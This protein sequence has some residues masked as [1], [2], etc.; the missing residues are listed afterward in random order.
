MLLAA[1]LLLALAA[2]TPEKDARRRQ[3]L[4]PPPPPVAT[5]P[6]PAAGADGSGAT[7]AP[8]EDD[9]AGPRPLLRQP[10]PPFAYDRPLLEVDG[11]RIMASELNE[12]VLYYRSFRPGS[13]DLLLMDAVAALLPLKAVQSRYQS[14]LFAMRDRV[15]Q[16]AEALRDGA[17]FAEAVAAFSDDDESD[18]PEGRYTF[19][20]ERAVQ[21]FDRIAFTAEPGSGPTAPFLTKYGF[22]IL[23]PLA[24]E[25]GAT[26][27]EDRATMRHLLVMYPGLK[28]MSDAGQDMRA[29]IDQQ[30]AAVRIRVLLP[31][32]ENLVPPERRAQLVR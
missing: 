3:P 9:G 10:P 19:G 5:P 26:A 11:A 23:E 20:R 6:L 28:T 24:Y 16:A 13:D 14:E 29:W 12:L 15:N 32:L 1:P 17:S 25:R 30:V 18:D 27:K 31:G 7:A 21:P 4:I 8:E 22:H 2:Q